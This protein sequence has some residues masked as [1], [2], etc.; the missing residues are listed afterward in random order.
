MLRQRRLCVLAKEQKRASTVC[1]CSRL[2]ELLKL[3]GR[4]LYWRQNM[5]VEHQFHHFLQKPPELFQLITLSLCD[6]PSCPE[7]CQRSRP[8]WGF[9]RFSDVHKWPPFLTCLLIPLIKHCYCV[10]RVCPF[11]CF[12]VLILPP[13]LR[14]LTAPTTSTTLGGWCSS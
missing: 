14:R 10:V 6:G 9:S 4:T 11:P 3:R 7:V 8:P 1:A 5:L 2:R 13:C 12:A